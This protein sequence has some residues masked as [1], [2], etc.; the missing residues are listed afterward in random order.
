MQTLRLSMWA[1]LD[2]DICNF[3]QAGIKHPAMIVADAYGPRVK[4]VCR[5]SQPITDPNS[6][7]E[8]KQHS[9][10]SDHRSCGINRE[11]YVAWKDYRFVRAED[12]YKKI[13]CIEPDENFFEIVDSLIRRASK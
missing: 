5:S 6:Q 4:I 3:G 1:L 13:R 12:L 9:G 8:H 10:L 7:L 2:F 11:G